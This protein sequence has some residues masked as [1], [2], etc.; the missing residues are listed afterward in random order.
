MNK[1]W[2]RLMR[3]L[4]LRNPP[5]K[6]ATEYLL[7]PEGE[8][9]PTDWACRIELAGDVVLLQYLELEGDR[10]YERS[11]V[12]YVDGDLDLTDLDLSVLCEEDDH[13]GRRLFMKLMHVADGGS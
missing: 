10:G 2:Q 8:P 6:E 5:F 13:P 12:L 3:H 1:T 7:C 9:P 4:Q 11:R